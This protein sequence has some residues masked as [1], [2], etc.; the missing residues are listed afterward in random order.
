[1]ARV[2]NWEA[3]GCLCYED[4]VV[5]SPSIVPLQRLGS[6]PRFPRVLE[7]TLHLPHFLL[8]FQFHF[9]KSQPHMM[10]LPPGVLHLGASKPIWGFRWWFVKPS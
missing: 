4:S 6:A 8:R 1:M 3:V 10:T 5:P 2:L 7:Q 9:T